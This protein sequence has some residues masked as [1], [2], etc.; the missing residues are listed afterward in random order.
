MKRLEPFAYFE[1]ASLAEAVDILSESKKDACLLA[2]GTDLLVRMKRGEIAPPVLVNLKRISGLSQIERVQG[3]V[4]IGALTSIAE[5]E[6]SSLL[7]AYHP[8]LADAAAVLGSPSIRNLATLGGNIGRASP[9]SD[10]APPLLVLKAR[11]NLAGPGGSR[12][13][14][15]ESFFTGPGTTI[16]QPGE[17]ITG[18]SLPDAE[19]RSG[20]AYLKLGRRDVMDCALVG[21]AVSI[22]LGKTDAEVKQVLVAM[23][24]CS[25]I[26]MRAAKVEQFLLSGPLTEVRIREAAAVAAAETSPISD[27]RASASYRLQMVKV[28]FSR[29]LT[30]ACRR[31][32]EKRGAL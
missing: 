11:L 32:T 31:A 25:S 16:L 7:Q 29:A 17:I 14:G 1:P 26:P 8:A 24:A 19:A 13:V 15:P 27:L 9:A 3:A 18:F 22:T 4:R 28:M 2:G 10:M 12:E 5:I 20:A 6:H 30:I 23:T 21:V